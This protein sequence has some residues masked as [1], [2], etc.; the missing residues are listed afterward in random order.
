M[1]IEIKVN[2]LSEHKNIFLSQDKCLFN[3]IE[4]NIDFNHIAERLLNIVV[5]WQ[6]KMI[7]PR[8]IDGKKYCVK[9]EKDSK[10]YE[11]QG[12]NMF[13]ENFNEFEYLIRE[14]ENN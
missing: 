1:K 3:G 7:N 8:T 10:V 4:K 11:F 9:I 13:P 12:A 5:T 2:S 6:P 14:I